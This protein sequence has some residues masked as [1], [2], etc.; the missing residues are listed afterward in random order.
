[1]STEEYTIIV[2]DAEADDAHAIAGLLS[3]LGYPQ[4]RPALDAQIKKLSKRMNDRV[5][6]AVRESQVVAVL[7]LHIMPMFH[8]DGKVCRVTSLV[9]SDKFR[10]KYIGR[11]LMDMAEAYAR[12]SG[13]VQVE[14]T[15]NERRADAHAFY[16]RLGYTAESHRFV[17]K[18]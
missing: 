8:L 2:R 11:R 17:K 14:V 1:M 15:S 18:I 16:D 13:C 6:V 9:V 3:D 12:A 4:D 5:L 7:S 10:K